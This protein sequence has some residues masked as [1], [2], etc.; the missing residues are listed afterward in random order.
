MMGNGRQIDIDTTESHITV[1]DY[2]RGIPLD[3]L[4]DVFGKDEH[5]R[6]IRL[7]GF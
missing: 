1:R 3:K 4:E 2:G 6:K 5:R 7:Q